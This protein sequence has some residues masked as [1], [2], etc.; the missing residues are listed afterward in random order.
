MKKVYLVWKDRNCN[1]VNPEWQELNGQEFY[2][3]IKQPENKRRLFI[4]FHGENEQ[5]CDI[6]I[7]STE[8][9]YVSWRKEKDHH[10]WIREGQAAIG[11][12][13]VSYHAM[14]TDDGCFGEELIS[15]PKSKFENF[16]ADKIV[17]EQ[18]SNVLNALTQDEWWLIEKIYKEEKSLSEVGELLGMSKVAI[19][20]RLNKV[21]AKLKNQIL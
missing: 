16:I 15:D 5:D 20:K 10:D 4:K 9:A 12:Q 11:Y 1:G 2:T 19:F 6:M 8:K 14:E 7:E 21:L 18:L 3:F 17:M 13:V